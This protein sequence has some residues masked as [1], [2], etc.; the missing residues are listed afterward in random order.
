MSNLTRTNLKSHQGQ[1]EMTSQ[2]PFSGASLPTAAV[3]STEL[4]SF[5]MAPWLRIEVQSGLGALCYPGLAPAPV[6]ESSPMTRAERSA[7]AVVSVTPQRRGAPL[8]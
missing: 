1:L 5:H 4:G 2:K 6:N 3:P 7:L 8:R